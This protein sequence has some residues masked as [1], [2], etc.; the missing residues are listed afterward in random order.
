MAKL[1]RY[2][3]HTESPFS[4]ADVQA[5]PNITQ[6]KSLTMV[7]EIT[8]EILHFSQPGRQYMQFKDAGTYVKFFRQ[9]IRML[10]DLSPSGVRLLCVVMETLKPGKYTVELSRSICAQL[11]YANLDGASFYRGLI[12]LLDHG[13]LARAGPS[14]YWVNPNTVFN[15]DRTVEKRKSVIKPKTRQDDIL[16]NEDEISG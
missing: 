14:T 2:A 8:G 11:G 6:S 15:G 1:D 16:E 13:V 3:V 4:V 7:S 5:K 10:A 9:G 12:D